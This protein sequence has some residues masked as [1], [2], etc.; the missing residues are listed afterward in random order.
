ME[1][2]KKSH[3]SLGKKIPN[4]DYYID[5]AGAVPL[6]QQVFSL[7]KFG[8]KYS[9]VAVYGK[10]IPL[11]G[12]MFIA[13]EAMIRGSKEYNTNTINEYIQIVEKMLYQ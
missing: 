9:I 4:V 8:T 2:A 7:G 11:S 5:A 6:L 10:E 13:N 3:L 12:N 1:F